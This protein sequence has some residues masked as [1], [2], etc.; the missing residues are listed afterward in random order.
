MLRRDMRQTVG[1][2]TADDKRRITPK[3]MM[4]AMPASERGVKKGR[5]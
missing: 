2:D 1:I 3:P 5:P 4:A